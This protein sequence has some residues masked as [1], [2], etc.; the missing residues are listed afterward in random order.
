MIFQGFMDCVSGVL[1]GMGV[2]LAC[3]IINLVGICGFRILWLL[4]V[5]PIPKYHTPQC[6]YIIYPITWVTTTIAELIL[7]RFT[8]K[9]RTAALPPQ[10][11]PSPNAK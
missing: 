7:L 6:L 9:K 3:M 4:T 5:F 2:S 11:A 10:S 8:L 1:R